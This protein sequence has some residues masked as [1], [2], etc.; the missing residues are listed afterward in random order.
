MRG[1]TIAIVLLL[2]MDAGA[3]HGQ[4]LQS[5]TK[6]LGFAVGLV[7]Y[8]TR[9]RVLNNAR[10]RGMLVTASFFRTRTRGASRRRFDLDI[11]VSRIGSRFERERDSYASSLA[12]AYSYSRRVASAARGLDVFLGGVTGV[13]SHIAFYE[14]WDDSHFYWL[15]SYY[16]GLRG[17]VTYPVRDGRSTF[18]SISMPLV[19]I[20]SRPEERILYKTV[21]PDFGWIVSKLHDNLRL[22]SVH[23]HLSLDATVG[24]MIGRS[25]EFRLG[26]F[27]RFLF[28]RNIVPSSREISILNHRVG[29][30]FVF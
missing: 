30:M 24:Y 2:L 15:T 27:W 17:L 10:H 11:T 18:V 4:D 6:D 13:D 23:R 26:I 9:E 20:V 7:E 19:A 1:W 3:A 29:L 25:D 8:Q 12:L 28:V 5:N 22:T 14:N 16:V 21:N